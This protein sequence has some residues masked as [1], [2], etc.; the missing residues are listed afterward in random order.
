LFREALELERKR[1]DSYGTRRSMETVLGFLGQNLFLQQR[2]DMAEPILR[3]A[4]SIY[5]KLHPTNPERFY[6]MNV[7]GGVLCG[8]ERCSEAESM[9]VQGYEEMRKRERLMDAN[10]RTR[11]PQAGERVVRF[12]EA[13][14]QPEKARAWREKLL[15]DNSKK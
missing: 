3:E 2:Y 15:E 14:N 6:W 7:L 8:Q 1:A 5:E 11:L 9:L 12:Y 4:L 13:T 10:W